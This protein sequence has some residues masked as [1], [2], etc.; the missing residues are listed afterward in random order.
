MNTEDAQTNHYCPHMN[1]DPIL[2]PDHVQ[3]RFSSQIDVNVYFNGRLIGSLKIPTGI[4]EDSV[5]IET[6]ARVQFSDQIRSVEKCVVVMGR[7]KLVNF[8][9]QTE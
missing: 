3:S 7:K 2:I 4:A 9:A 5:A 6:K 1:I 8:V